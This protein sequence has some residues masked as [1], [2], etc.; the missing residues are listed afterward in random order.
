MHANGVLLSETGLC[1]LS[2]A[3]GE[4][5]VDSFVEIFAAALASTGQPRHAAE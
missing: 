3:M 1:A 2:T 4:A 5:E